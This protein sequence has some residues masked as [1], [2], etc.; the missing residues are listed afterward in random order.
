MEKGWFVASEE[1]NSG[2]EFSTVIGLVTRQLLLSMSA[3]RRFGDRVKRALGVLKAF[4][5]VS[6]MGVKVDLDV[7][8]VIGTADSG[9]LRRDVGD[10]FVEIGKL[11]ASDGAGVVFLFDELHTRRNDGSLDVLDLAL[12]RVAQRGLPV[13]MVGA[14][15]FPGTWVDD[16]DEPEHSD[17]STYASRMYRLLR[18]RPLSGADT[19]RALSVPAERVGVDVDEAALDVAITFTRGHPWFIQLLGEAAWDA[20]TGST[21][22]RE[23]VTMAAA[24]IRKRLYADFFPQLLRGLPSEATQVLEILAKRGTA[25]LEVIEDDIGDHDGSGAWEAV[26][27]LLAREIIQLCDAE[28]GG[29]LSVFDGLSL[30]VPLL[31]EYVL[32][33]SSPQ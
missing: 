29:G 13:T 21:I 8:A 32:A 6:A 23:D 2:D 33:R 28:R 10:L 26:D 3:S 1:L 22:T 18:L 30:A 5:A 19:R 15:I 17:I 27:A 12:H 14:G 25:T 11:A 24:S 7:D 4:S 31:N 9:V 20:A 16:G